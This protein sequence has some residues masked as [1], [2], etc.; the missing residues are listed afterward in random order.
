MGLLGD[1]DEESTGSTDSTEEEEPVHMEVKATEVDE[2]DI[3][4]PDRPDVIQSNE[5]M[6]SDNRPIEKKEHVEPRRGNQEAGNK[7]TTSDLL[8]STGYKNFSNL[9]WVKYVLLGM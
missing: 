6:K 3:P 5:K 1:L 2:K 7:I 9:E 4:S 8:E